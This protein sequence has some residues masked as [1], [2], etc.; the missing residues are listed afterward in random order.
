MEIAPRNTSY[1]ERAHIPAP[2][3]VSLVRVCFVTILFLPRG[4][5]LLPDDRLIHHHLARFH[6]PQYFGRSPM[7]DVR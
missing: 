7:S 2:R 1:I 6:H 5:I 3:R 4:L